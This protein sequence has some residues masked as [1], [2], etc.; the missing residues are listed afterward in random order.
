MPPWDNEEAQ[1]NQSVSTWYGK[2]KPRVCGPNP[3]PQVLQQQIMYKPRMQK[4]AVKAHA[5]ATREDNKERHKILQTQDSNHAKVRAL[6][7]L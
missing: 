3:T 7:Y 2:I 6:K 4:H 5:T 1:T